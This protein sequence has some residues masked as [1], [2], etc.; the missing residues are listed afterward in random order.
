M[1]ANINTT[2]AMAVRLATPYLFAALAG[3]R[4]LPSQRVRGRHGARV[5]HGGLLQRAAHGENAAEQ[6]Y[7]YEI[8]IRECLDHKN[9]P[10]SLCRA[11]RRGGRAPF[12]AV[13]FIITHSSE[14][15]YLVFSLF[16]MLY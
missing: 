9:T 4:H 12:S 1:M 7:K 5:G 16:G 13:F 3:G 10:F 14:I 2:L 11:Y 8:D 6:Q 15:V